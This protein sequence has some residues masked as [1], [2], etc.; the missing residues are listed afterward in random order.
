MAARL[1]RAPAFGLSLGAV[2][3]IVWLALE[4]AWTAKASLALAIIVVSATLAG[5]AAAWA[6]DWLAARSLPTRFA[7]ALLVLA[8]GTTGFASFALFVRALWTTAPPSDSLG[9]VVFFT[10]TLAVSALIS[11]LGLAA[12]LL[13]VPGLPLLLLFALI[14]ARRPR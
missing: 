7:A 11:F 2:F 3:A 12:P 13:F 9:H 8:V 1:L 6:A 10:I 5:I 4:R 14:V